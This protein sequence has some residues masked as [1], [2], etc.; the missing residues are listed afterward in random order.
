[1]VDFRKLLRGFGQSQTTSSHDA[2]PAVVPAGA[3]PPREN[4]RT[5][6]LNSDSEFVA[7][8]FWLLLGRPVDEHNLKERTR[9]LE[10]GQARSAI[11]LALTSSSEFRLRR[12]SLQERPIHA[13]RDR[14]FEQG[15]LMLG[16]DGAFV[17]ACYACILGRDADPAGRAT[18][19]AKLADG[20]SRHT[21]LYALLLSDEFEQRY[22]ELCPVGGV[23]PV[24]SQLCEL[25]NPAKWDNPEWMAMLEELQL[26]AAPKMAMHRKA[27]EFTQAIWGLQRLDALTPDAV[28]LSVG[29]G[30]ESLVY[31]LA[32]R[33]AHVVAT[34]LYPGEWL[35]SRSAEGDVRV[36]THPEE[37]APFPYRRE[38]L[39][40]LQMDGRYLAF[41]SGTFDVAYS[42]SSVEH[43][44]GWEGARRAV[45]EM[46]RVVRKGG[47]IVLATEWCLSGPPHEEVFQPDE[48]RR[49]ID[50]PDCTLVEPLD[51]RVWCRYPQRPVDLQRNPY[52]TP[53]ML[54]QLE[55]T[56][57]TSVMVFLRKGA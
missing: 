22:R 24:D 52:E 57:F 23:L 16:A 45:E 33:V 40:F 27:Y 15:L 50:L 5:T 39:R 25:A 3:V 4:T 12:W 9:A 43:F 44:G 29:A 14:A 10:L 36:I 37:F 19:L 20:E 51:D 1:M 47:L 7:A 32:N 54:V 41:K 31:W 11:L 46:A 13:T 6:V 48:F 18:Y 38:R 30:H 26:P 2:A 55:G 8:A 49:L 53:H 56:V 28:V 21:V 42:L 35:A 17:D 34:D